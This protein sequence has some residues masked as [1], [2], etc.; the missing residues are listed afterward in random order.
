[1]TIDLNALR[2]RVHAANVARGWWRDTDGNCTRGKRSVPTALCLIHSEVSEGMEGDRK[3]LMDDKLPHRSM[4]EVELA[5]V[6]IRG[7]DLAGGYDV[8]LNVTQAVHEGRLA[9]FL[10][11]IDIAGA[12]TPSILATLHYTISEGL[13]A[14][15]TASYLRIAPILDHV[16]A[17]ARHL[18][19]DLFGAIE[20]K[21]AVN[22]TRADHDPA[23]RAKIGGK[24]Y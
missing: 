9:I 2:D 17:I 13:H 22:A 5:D 11:F 1:M 24:A 19:L 15:M 21:L 23:E 7:L 10:E 3:S 6:Y 16:E 4:L 12:D 14:W 20:E 8:D 18:K